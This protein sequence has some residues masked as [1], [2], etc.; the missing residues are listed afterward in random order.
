M[1]REGSD[2]KCGMELRNGKADKMSAEEGST[3]EDDIDSGL[4][5][6]KVVGGK[7][8]FWTGE[9]GFGI[10]ERLVVGIVVAAVGGKV[11]DVG[12]DARDCVGRWE[13]MEGVGDAIEG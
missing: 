10:L 9:M 2:G 1:G 3:R 4:R 12:G 6:G 13:K 5:A 8:K 11:G 7:G